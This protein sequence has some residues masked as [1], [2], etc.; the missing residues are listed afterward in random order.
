MGG[1]IW[2]KKKEK[3]KQKEKYNWKGLFFMVKAPKIESSKWAL[4][5][6]RLSS[7]LL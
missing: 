2:E 4:I 7:W 1:I 6:F 5:S 3:K